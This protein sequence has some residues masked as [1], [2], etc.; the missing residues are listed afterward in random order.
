MKQTLV[1]VAPQN[2]RATDADNQRYRIKDSVFQ[3]EVLIESAN[4]Q[5]VTTSSSIPGQT[6]SLYHVLYQPCPNS[7]RKKPEAV[8]F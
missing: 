6:I 8:Y 1:V 3:N 4:I 5:N 7:R 2:V